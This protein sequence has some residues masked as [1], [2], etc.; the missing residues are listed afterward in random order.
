MLSYTRLL[1]E[2]LPLSVSLAQLTLSVNS[3]SIGARLLHH[4]YCVLAMSNTYPMALLL[5]D[6]RCVVVGGGV[7][8]TR[9]V[10]GLPEAGAAVTVVALKMTEEL[11]RLAARGKIDA[12]V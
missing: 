5:A 7:V 4:N 12:K 6:K 8:A 11:Q 10:S 2:P 9:K 3:T 1:L